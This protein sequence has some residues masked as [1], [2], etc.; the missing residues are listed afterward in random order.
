MLQV[1]ALPTV[2][3]PL[4]LSNV[5]IL[6]ALN[7]FQVETFCE[8]KGIDKIFYPYLWLKPLRGVSLGSFFLFWSVVMWHPN[9]WHFT[10]MEVFSRS[11]FLK[12]GHSRPLFIYFCLFNT[13]DNKQMFN[14]ILPMMGVEPRTSGI[15]SDRSTNWATTTSRYILFIRILFYKKIVWKSSGMFYIFTENTL[16]RGDFMAGLQFDYIGFDQRR[17]YFAICM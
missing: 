8:R 6:D 3:Q 11:F 1:T 16:Q 4:P 5:P 15:I 9:R 10:S 12:V 7:S 2:P 13:V 14:K 17:K